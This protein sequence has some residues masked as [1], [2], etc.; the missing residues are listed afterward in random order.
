[1]K[2]PA[3]FSHATNASPSETWSPPRAG[4]RVDRQ[5]LDAGIDRAAAALM[6]TQAPEGYW[7]FDLEADASITAEYVLMMHF[8]DEIDSTLESQLAAY[9]RSAQGAH[10]GWGLF[11]DSAPDLSCSVK[12]YFA[13]KLAGDDSAAPHMGRARSAILEGTKT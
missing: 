11:P 5:A 2:Q 7:R 13:L 10:G 3:L 4:V 8:M 9:L 12:A 6:E 1:M